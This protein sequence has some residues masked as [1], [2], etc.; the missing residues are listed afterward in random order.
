MA[1]A[2]YCLPYTDI[3]S[4]I[5]QG[6]D[7]LYLTLCSKEKGD[8]LC[9]TLNPLQALTLAEGLCHMTSKFKLAD[10]ENVSIYGDMAIS[11]E[12]L[13]DEGD[14]ETEKKEKMDKTDRKNGPIADEADRETEPIEDTGCSYEAKP[15][16]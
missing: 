9:V 16:A 12:P 7:V 6:D 13:M 5:R 10:V 14:V 4:T 3:D 2:T 8:T 1:Y 15:A 11:Y